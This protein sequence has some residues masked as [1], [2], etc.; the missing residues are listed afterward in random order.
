[1]FKS[2][3]PS[4]YLIQIMIINFYRSISLVVLL[5]IGSNVV[6]WADSECA[7]EYVAL[8]DSILSNITG[9]DAFS[10]TISVL[11]F[12]AKPDSGKDC[13]KS[14]E[15][16]INK[17]NS[18]GGAV[19]LVPKGEY[20][21]KGPVNFM[22]NVNLHLCEG[23][24]LKFDPDPQYYPIVDTSWEGT[25]CYNYSPMIRAY[26][27]ENVAITGNGTIDGN[28]MST[29]ATWR[30][31]QK[32]AQLR[33]REMNHDRI[34]VINRQFGENDWLRPQLVQFY[35]CSRVTI[36]GVK[37]INSPFWCIH[38]L[39]SDNIIC[40]GIRYDAKLV[41]NDG[42]DPESSKNILIEDVHFD[43]GDDNI[44]I[45]SGR[46]HDGRDESTPPTEN[47][48]IRNC[49]F[50]GLH[51]VVLGSELSGGIRN[52][53]IENCDYAG[54]CKRGIYLKSNP[55]RG[56]FV[57]NIYVVNC[58]F[59]DVEDLFYITASYAGEGQGNDK[60]TKINDIHV[61]GL[62]ADNVANAAVVIQGIKSLPIKNVTFKNLEAGT[63]KIGLSV[64]N[65]EGVT[66]SDCFIGGR[67]GVPSQV[68]DKDHLFDRK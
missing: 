2:I 13:L 23:A 29:F 47:I 28:A 16:A 61:D 35:Q 1:M 65:S 38:L 33:S 24:V 8:R 31:K 5:M 54:Y 53:V 43:N 3:Y 36:E 11:K 40:R 37:I 45:K 49:H 26:R 46:D 63:A 67:A 20:L 55:D 39:R 41:N 9:A 25:Y 59:G 4:I 66:F 32:A 57:N 62:S 12:G 60:F 50:K 22:S 14:F 18:K 19:V 34:P 7:N 27:V 10:D 15:K 30:A 58:K 56:G 68:T 6:T 52:I 48:V 42:I 17:A 64:E 44:A 21:L 51:A